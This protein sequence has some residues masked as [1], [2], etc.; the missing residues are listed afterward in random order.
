MPKTLEL[1]YPTEKS[2]DGL[3]IWVK[4]TEDQYSQMKA[5]M[6][7]E[8]LTLEKSYDKVMENETR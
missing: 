7:K 4:V 3:R 2:K 1:T 5:L 8:S 6:N